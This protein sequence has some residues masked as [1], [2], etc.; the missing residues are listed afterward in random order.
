[1]SFSQIALW[2]Q[3]WWKWRYVVDLIFQRTWILNLNKSSNCDGSKWQ[4]GR[5]SSITK[6]I[7]EIMAHFCQMFEHPSMK[8]AQQFPNFLISK[9][10][11]SKHISFKKML[12]DA[13]VLGNLLDC[14][15]GKKKLLWFVCPTRNIFSYM[16]L[17]LIRFYWKYFSRL[18][19]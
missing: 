11:T 16:K 8:K 4:G 5:P 6:T 14:S 18:P 3:K 19:D 10:L 7:F 1:M 15:N 17:Y 2:F 12:L 13:G 9:R